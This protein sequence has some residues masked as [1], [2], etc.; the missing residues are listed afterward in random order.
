MPMRVLFT[1]KIKQ[2][3]LHPFKN[4][5]TNIDK[6]EM[7]IINIKYNVPLSDSRFLL[8]N[9]LCTLSCQAFLPRRV[10][11]EHFNSLLIFSASIE[12]RFLFGILHKTSPALKHFDGCQV[13]L[14]YS[15]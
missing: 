5:N 1:G 4:M 11:A 8:S 12:N 15:H 10:E 2:I 7:T 14:A 6:K 9:S 13:T 3:Y